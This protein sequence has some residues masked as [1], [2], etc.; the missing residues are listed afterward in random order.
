MR[1]TQAFTRKAFKLLDSKSMIAFAVAKDENGSAIGWQIAWDKAMAAKYRV[2]Q[3]LKNKGYKTVTLQCGNEEFG[4]LLKRGFWVV[5]KT[6]YTNAN[7]ATITAYGMGADGG[8]YDRA[9][10]KAKAQIQH[11]YQDWQ[12][13]YGYQI[14]KRGIF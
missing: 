3:S 11:Y 14:S 5:I 4:H 7:G 1:L 9:V 8:D 6:T 2:K 10:V 12:E 13:A